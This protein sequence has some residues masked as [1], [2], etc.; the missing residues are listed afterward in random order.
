MVTVTAAEPQWYEYQPSMDTSSM[1]ISSGDT[2]SIAANKIHHHEMTATEYDKKEYPFSYV[3]PSTISTTPVASYA[4]PD[5]YIIMSYSSGVPYIHHFGKS[6]VDSESNYIYNARVY[7]NGYPLSKVLKT[8]ASPKF[9]NRVYNGVYNGLYNP[10]NG[11]RHISKR[12]PQGYPQYIY[13]PNVY[14]TGY[15]YIK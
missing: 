2:T 15:N 14:A 7:K 1:K 10:Y 5:A 8:I 3:K 12:E 11:V 13:H 6:N 4:I 9:Y